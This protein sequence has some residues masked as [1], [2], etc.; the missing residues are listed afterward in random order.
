MYASCVAIYSNVH[1]TALLSKPADSKATLLE[2]LSI[3]KNKHGVG[4]KV[5]KLVMVGDGKT[6]DI[7]INLLKD[8]T[9]MT[10]PGFYPTLMNGIS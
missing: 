8:I 1:F 7:L 6:Y 10:C 5:D 2:V 3:L 9:Q 4:D